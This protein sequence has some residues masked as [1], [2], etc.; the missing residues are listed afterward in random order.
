MK[1][2]GTLSICLLL[3]V[4]P[5]CRRVVEWGK[6]CFYQGESIPFDKPL[7]KRSI[8]SFAAY[9]EFDTVARFDALWLSNEVRTEYARLHAYTY[10]KSDAFYQALLRRQLEENKHFITFYVL[11]LF[12]AP[13]GD[14]ESEWSLFLQVNGTNIAPS[15][16]KVIELLP[17]Y[18]TFLGTRCSKFRVPYRVMFDAKDIED[19]AVLS[20]DTKEIELIFRS[21]NRELTL[22]WDYAMPDAGEN[23]IQNVAPAPASDASPSAPVE[24]APTVPSAPE[25]AET[26]AVSNDVAQAAP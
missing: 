9:D 1:K 5:G 13:L 4:L 10:G 16:I 21:T 22:R 24:Q 26:I 2:Y 3:C 14:S 23:K 12:D 7:M 20:Q 25:P 6:K 18:K 15:E 19:Q 11:S 17:E 8:K